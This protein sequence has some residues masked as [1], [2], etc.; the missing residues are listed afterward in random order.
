MI[1]NNCSFK[2]LCKYT[3]LVDKLNNDLKEAP[4]PLDINCGNFKSTQ[5]TKTTQKREEVSEY[6]YAGRVCPNCG[7]TN[8]R[9]SM[10]E[11]YDTEGFLGLKHFKYTDYYT[12]D[13]CGH[14]FGGRKEYY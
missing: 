11:H 9:K 1:C 6:I 5:Q 13:D 7:G 4:I 3:D 10:C 2:P 14:D 8:T 12:C